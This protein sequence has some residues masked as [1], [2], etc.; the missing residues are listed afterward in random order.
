MNENCTFCEVEKKINNV[1]PDVYAV[2]K[3]YLVDVEIQESNLILNNV[4]DRT[5]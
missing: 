2:I 4:A 3:G 5:A 1:I